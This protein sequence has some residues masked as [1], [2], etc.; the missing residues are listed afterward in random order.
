MEDFQFIAGVQFSK[1][2]KKVVAFYYIAGTLYDAHHQT[3]IPN[4]IH[5]KLLHTH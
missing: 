5:N 4:L 1:L 2:L 3:W